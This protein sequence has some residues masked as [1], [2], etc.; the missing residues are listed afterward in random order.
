MI[1]D[2]FTIVDADLAKD[3]EEYQKFYA[4]DAAPAPSQPGGAP[5]GAAPLGPGSALPSFPTGF[6][7]PARFTSF[8]A[9]F[10]T[11]EFW[12][13][14]FDVDAADVVS[15]IRAVFLLLPPPYLLPPN[16]AQLSDPEAPPLA[17]MTANVQMDT[18]VD[19]DDTAALYSDPHAAYNHPWAQT[20]GL[21][22]APVSVGYPDLYGPT[23]IGA[24]IGV[25]LAI[26]PHATLIGPQ[27]S[28]SAA[29]PSD[30]P[31]VAY[32]R[33]S[34]E[35]K[36]VLSFGSIWVVYVFNLLAAVGVWATLRWRGHGGLP[37]T[38]VVALA[39]LFG[40]SFVPYVFALIT[41]LLVGLWPLQMSAMAVATGLAALNP[42]LALRN[43]QVGNLKLNDPYL[44][45]V[46]HFPWCIM[47][48]TWV[49]PIL[50]GVVYLPHI[51]SDDL[52]RNAAAVYCFQHHCLD[53]L[54]GGAWV[55]TRSL[56]ALPW[57]PP[58]RRSPPYSHGERCAVGT[59]PR[60][61][62]GHLLV[63]TMRSVYR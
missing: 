40:Y 36:F 14:L 58:R 55:G 5:A 47:G 32:V 16:R 37:G 8:S 22:G 62:R 49:Y 57:R 30:P 17:S 23:W 21:S 53:L 25:L 44:C 29:T 54:L 20:L 1:S 28:A 43:G 50:R 45:D 2:E 27:P 13:S 11:I 61:I 35:A 59:L 60:N 19:E 3:S 56:H 4:E 10:Y 52:S 39:C 42:I 63:L 48:C 34:E 9:P 15:R 46:R 6:T 18:A 7:L 51:T 24:T 31:L 38:G 33:A 12:Q 26:V 41:F